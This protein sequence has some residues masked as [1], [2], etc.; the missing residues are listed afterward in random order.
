MRSGGFTIL[1]FLLVMVIM[2]VMVM[3]LT[4]T[5]G[6]VG[7]VSLDAAT[8]RAQSDIRYAQERAMSTGRNHGVVFNAVTG[9]Y[10]VYD[11]TVSTPVTSPLTRQPMI[12]TLQNFQS[13]SIRNNY[14]VEFNRS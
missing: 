10:T 9:T 6:D 14:Q 4:N 11:T 12:Q 8:W 7:M 5:L 13:V 1:E 2:G 3:T